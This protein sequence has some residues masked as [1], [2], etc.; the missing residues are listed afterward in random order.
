MSAI[1]TMAWPAWGLPLSPLGE[2]VRVRGL[3][4]DDTGLAHLQEISRL[5]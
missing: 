4:T 2:K 3:G 5:A 1:S